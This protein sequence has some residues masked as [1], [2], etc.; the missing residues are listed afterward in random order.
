MVELCRWM[1]NLV[2]GWARDFS[3]GWLMLRGK[4]LVIG[5]SDGWWVAGG[6][7]NFGGRWCVGGI[8]EGVGMC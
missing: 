4:L 7:G 1:G 2:F 6:E 5:V 3:G 8:I